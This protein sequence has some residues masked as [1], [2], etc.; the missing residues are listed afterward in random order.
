MAKVEKSCKFCNKSFLAEVR[1]VNRGNGKFCS[2]SCS[3]KSHKKEKVPNVECGT[4]GKGLYRT[5][6]HIKASRS[7]FFFCNR[8]CLR[9]AQRL[10]GIEEIHPQHFNSN[11]N[12][13][14]ICFR[15]HKKECVICGES[16]IVAVH[17]YDHNHSNNDPA[18]L[19]PLCPT[20]HQY[21]HSKFADMVKEK[22]DSYILS[23]LS[24]QEST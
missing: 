9:K 23:F 11:K 18:N 20:H 2:L 8:E 1:E 22:I 7:G 12:Y 21:V 3:S 4:C 16:N 5:K 13:R 15:N 19:V 17:H 6:S 24:C 14:S 10:D